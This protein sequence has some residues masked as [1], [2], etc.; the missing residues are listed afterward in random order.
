MAKLLDKTKK[1]GPARAKMFSSNDS[2][3]NGT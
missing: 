2:S 1:A 3:M